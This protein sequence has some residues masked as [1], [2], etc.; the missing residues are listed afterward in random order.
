[1]ASG[2]TAPCPAL[3]GAPRFGF[4]VGLMSLSSIPIE[5][6]ILWSRAVM[7]GPRLRVLLTP[8]LSVEHL[9]IPTLS[10]N[11]ADKNLHRLT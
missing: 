8:P 10:S 9:Q 3:E 11:F 7:V 6:P 1:V 2:A 4:K 5:I